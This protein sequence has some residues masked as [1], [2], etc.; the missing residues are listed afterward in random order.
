MDSPYPVISNT[1]KGTI[2]VCSVRSVSSFVSFRLS[3]PP[4]LQIRGKRGWEL[5]V[6][7]RGWIEGGKRESEVPFPK[8][9]FLPKIFMEKYFCQNIYLIQ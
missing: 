6:G 7:C 5:Y 4:Q 9:I 3:P 2:I 1:I 8:K